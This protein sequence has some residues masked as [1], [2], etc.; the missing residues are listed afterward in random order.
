M[1]KKLLLLGLLRRQEM[2]GYQLNE[3]IDN[4]LALC[5]DLKK[6]TAYYLLDQMS[7]DGWISAEAE[8]EG[9]DQR[10]GEIFPPVRGKL[11][12][13]KPRVVYCN[14]GQIGMLLR[15]AGFHQGP[16]RTGGERLLDILVAIETFALERHEQVAG[17]DAACVRGHANEPH[18]AEVRA[19]LECRRNFAEPH[20]SS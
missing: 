1:E 4:N 18:F 16:G 17:L 10:Q 6:P 2:H 20:H 14:H 8:Q 13:R 5:T 12:Q 19:A 7:K 11:A 15:P 9:A 3:F